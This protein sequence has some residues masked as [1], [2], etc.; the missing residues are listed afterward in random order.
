MKKVLMIAYQFP[1]MGGAGV[2]RTAKFAKYLPEFDWEPIIF[3][4]EAVK[5]HV[6]D[7]SL[8]EDIPQGL[9]IIRTKPYDIREWPSILGLG[10]KWLSRKLIYPDGERIWQVLNRKAAI[11]A[12]LTEKV[13]LIYTT[14]YPY[15]DHL[16]GLELKKEFPHIPWVVDFRDEWTNNPYILDMNYPA[17]RTRIEKKMER[18]VVENCDYFITNTPIMLKNFQ[19]DYPT[20]TK[21]NS[22]VISNGYDEED[23][24]ELNRAKP[25]NDKFV[26]TY[27]GAIYGQRRP[28]SF[29]QA[30][31]EL[32]KEGKILKHK[33]EVRLIGEYAQKALDE[34]I[35]NYQLEDVVKVFPYMPHLESIQKLLES[36]TLLLIIGSGPGAATF[37]T[38]K[39][40]EYMNTG[41]PI[42][43]LAPPE[44]VAA[45]V[46]KESQTGYIAD[47]QDILGIKENIQVLYKKWDRQEEAVT[48]QWNI[49]EQ[50]ERKM[51][52]KRLAE[53]LDGVLLGR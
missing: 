11:E 6:Q 36:D 50:Y 33:I 29:F 10:G 42:L 21:K 13:D 5:G 17:F 15:S 30:L 12:V 19:N 40:F 31:Q 7:P 51:L 25:T 27:T 45:Q 2:Q 18:A 22:I 49:I 28:D 52:T 44:G 4:R 9:K 41:R 16:M 20:L 53:I 32:I 1:P 47:D 38:G 48:P 39:I 26:I 37:Y 46:L 34:K 24:A 43:A 23:F 3:T 35:T 14:S 8:L